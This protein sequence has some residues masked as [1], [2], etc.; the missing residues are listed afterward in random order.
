MNPCQKLPQEITLVLTSRT[1]QLR[2]SNVGMLLLILR[3]SQ[4]LAVLTLLHRSLFLTTP[5]KFAMVIRLSWIATLLTSLANLT[6]SRRRLIG[7]QEKLLKQTQSQ[8]N[9]EM[10]VSW[11]LFRASQCALRLF[12]IFHLWVA[13]LFEMRQ[14][15]AVGVIKSVTPKDV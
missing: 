13:L 1:S 15:V 12:Q 3:I 9:L 4:L 10:L 14:T 5:V 6:K 7:V 8:L 2:T 11:G